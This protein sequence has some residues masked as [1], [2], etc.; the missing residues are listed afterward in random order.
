MKHYANH[1]RMYAGAP[2]LEQLG[3]SLASKA[4]DIADLWEAHVSGGPQAVAWRGVVAQAEPRPR[5]GKRH[6]QCV[7][8]PGRGARKHSLQAPVGSEQEVEVLRE[9]SRS[10]HEVQAGTTLEADVVSGP[11]ARRHHGVQQ[12]QLQ[13]LRRV[14]QGLLVKRLFGM[15][16]TLL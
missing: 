16:S 13:A 5:A 15:L 14:Q 10:I 9:P 6:P 8:H 11:V 4:T 7:G 3:A 1:A 12:Q 2:S